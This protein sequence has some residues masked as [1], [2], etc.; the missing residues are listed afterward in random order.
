MDK[1]SVD[2]R[3]TFKGDGEHQ[4]LVLQIKPFSLESHADMCA[5]Q[6]GVGRPRRLTEQE[7]QTLLSILGEDFAKYLR[8]A[9]E[10]EIK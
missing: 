5:I 9:K 1:Q 8:Q 4:D 7:I 6:A 2:W 3:V 10:D